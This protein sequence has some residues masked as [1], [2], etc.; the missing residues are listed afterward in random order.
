MSRPNITEGP[1]PRLEVIT[2]SRQTIALDQHVLRQSAAPVDFGAM[3]REERWHLVRALLHAL[4][5]GP[6]GSGL[7]APMTGVALRVIVTTAGEE[8]LAMFNPRIIATSGPNREADEGNLSLPGLRAPVVRPRDVTVEWQSP[9][10]GQLQTATFEG[11]TARVL[12]HELEILD[13]RMFIDHAASPPLGLWRSE[14]DLAS[15][16]ASTVFEDGADARPPIEALGIALLP[17]ALHRLDGVLTRPGTSVD[18]EVL[19]RDGLRG[20]TQSMFRVLYRHRGVG[21]AAP[22]VGLGLRLI[23]VDDGDSPALALINP[24][25]VDRDEREEV[26]LEGCLSI[27][28]WRGEVSRSTAVK[29]RTDT[30]DGEQIELDFKGHLARIAQHEIDH[31]DG[32]LYPSRMDPERRLEATDPDAVA[33][34]LLKTLQ[35]R[36]TRA[37]ADRATIARSTPKRRGKR[38]R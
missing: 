27:P 11:W 28:G 3:S 31:L 9:G 4:H 22:Q 30:V 38:R 35:Q 1:P 37:S 10:T 32:V 23:A 34:D 29:V 6:L 18:H 33:D 19:G 20:L 24:Q 7:A 15:R 2:A 17:P 26:S 25:I 14:E 13:G 21:L 36:D 5:V 8:P 12:Q 16:A